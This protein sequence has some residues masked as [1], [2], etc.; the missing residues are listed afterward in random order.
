MT[1]KVCKTCGVEKPETKEFFSLR[2]SKR[3]KSLRAKNPCR[4]CQRAV[5]HKSYLQNRDRVLAATKARATARTKEER[6]RR[7]RGQWLV[8]RYGI[9]QADYD[10]MLADQ[11]GVCAICGLHR[12]PR[13]RH[14]MHVDHNHRTGAVRAILCSSCNIGIAQF[15]ED[16]EK[17]MLAIRYLLRHNQSASMAA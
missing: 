3:Y 8:R 2:Y 14:A 5:C 10:R 6:L 12:P 4:E 13:G 16:I 11:G 9:T 15:G 17:M 7:N 1:T